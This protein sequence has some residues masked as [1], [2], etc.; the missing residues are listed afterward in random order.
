ML[1]RRE[2]VALGW[3]ASGARFDFVVCNLCCVSTTFCVGDAFVT[4]VEGDPRCALLKIRF[5][6]SGRPFVG[7]NL[8]I[9]CPLWGCAGPL[10]PPPL[11]S[12]LLSYCKLHIVLLVAR[13]PPPRC[14]EFLREE[15]GVLGALRG[16]SFGIRVNAP[17]YAKFPANVKIFW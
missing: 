16:E 10:L 6:R 7:K 9:S 13:Q 2:V 11:W 14:R 5:L 8:E 1:I 15:S 12:R 17:G 4:D 3:K